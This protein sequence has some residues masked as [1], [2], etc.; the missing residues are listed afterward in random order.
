MDFPKPLGALW[1]LGDIFIG[2]YYSKFDWV[3]NHQGFVDAVKGVE[4]K[5]E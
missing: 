1:I 5:A 3:D 4:I 2:K